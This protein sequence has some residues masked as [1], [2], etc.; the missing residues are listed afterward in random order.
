MAVDDLT[1]YGWNE[2]WR[3]VLA[4]VAGTQPN[5]ELHPARVVRH[6]GVAVD[7]VTDAGVVTV[8]LRRGLERAPVVGDWVAVEG[9]AD[10]RTLVAVLE[11]TTLLER[12]SVRSGARHPLVANIDQVL[13]TCGLDRPLNPGRIHRSATIAWEAGAAPTVVLTK[14][15]L[16][17]GN[18]TATADAV[19][20]E[21]PG[22]DVLVTS[23]VDGTGLG[24]LRQVIG[25][26]TVAL[27]GESGSGK[28]SLVNALCGDTV[29]TTGLVR[30]HDR[31]GRHTTTSREL[32]LLTGGG[33]VVDTPGLRALGVWADEESVDATFDDIAELSEGCRFR[34][35]AHDREP[36]CAVRAAIE[37]GQLDQR[38]LQAFH[39]LEQEASG[40]GIPRGDQR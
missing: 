40:R 2:D 22:L 37:D 6:H 17:P 13:I 3:A 38:R 11:R 39:Q 1:S 28:S 18:E 34:D 36:G 14:A 29:A 19:R 25:K 16:S 9:A 8:P 4:K 23:A 30:E 15:D 32:Y 26:A 7:V 35:C 27:L 5:R 24:R 10:H 21:H 12:R 20:E 31:K 33:L